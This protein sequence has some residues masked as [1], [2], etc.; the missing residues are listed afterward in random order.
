MTRKISFLLTRGGYALAFALLGAPALAQTAG[1]EAPGVSGT[2]IVQMLLGLALIIAVLFAGAYVLRKVNGGRSFGN[3]GP[4]RMVGALML[5][6]RERIILVEVGDR[7]IVVGVVP[8]QIK[9][10]HTLDKGELPAQTGDKPFSLW[11]KQ[12]TERKHEKN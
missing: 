1:A 12:M 2:A 3:S 6:P 4:L 10:L 7:W 11:L 9:T 8:G 5:S